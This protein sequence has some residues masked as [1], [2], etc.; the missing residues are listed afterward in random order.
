[1]G[2][3]DKVYFTERGLM[4]P[5]YVCKASVQ[6]VLFPVYIHNLEKFVLICRPFPTKTPYQ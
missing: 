2:S 6:K 5:G 1:M 3:F 4:A